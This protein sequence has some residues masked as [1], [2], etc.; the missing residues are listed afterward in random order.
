MMDGATI[1]VVFIFLLVVAVFAGIGIGLVIGLVLWGRNEDQAS[2]LPQQPV[3]Q[4]AAYAPAL[5]AQGGNA[6]L[7]LPVADVVL[8]SV[9]SAPEPDGAQVDEQIAAVP[10]RG[11][12]TSM[13]EPVVAPIPLA[14]EPVHPAR[15]T[16]SWSVALA[17]GVIVICCI[18]TLLLAALTA[19]T[20]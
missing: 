4:P 20:R 18:C 5:S 13:D 3:A 15:R 17:I 16:Q 8:Q 19:L 1:L 14:A 11:A 10:L 7:P 12:V 2:P 9:A 6:V